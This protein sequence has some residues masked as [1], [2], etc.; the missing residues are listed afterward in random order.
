MAMLHFVRLD[1]TLST[2]KSRAWEHENACL[3]DI[4]VLYMFIAPV[5]YLRIAVGDILVGG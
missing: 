5:V 3:S 1:N 4:L 2:V